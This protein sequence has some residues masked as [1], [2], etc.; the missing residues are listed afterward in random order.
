MKIRTLYILMAASM[1]FSSCKKSPEVFSNMMK[2]SPS[3]G[4][5]ESS[6]IAELL[7]DGM[8]MEDLEETNPEL[9]K[10]MQAY[11]QYQTTVLQK[12]ELGLDPVEWDNGTDPRIAQWSEVFAHSTDWSADAAEV[13]QKVFSG[14]IAGTSYY[15]FLQSL[16]K[17]NKYELVFFNDGS[18]ATVF[19]KTGISQRWLE[20]SLSFSLVAAI[21]CERSFE[22]RTEQDSRLT[23]LDDEQNKNE[24]EW[25]SHRDALVRSWNVVSD[26]LKTYQKQFNTVLTKVNIKPHQQW[27]D[28]HVAWIE[29]EITYSTSH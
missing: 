25:V 18:T 26:R 24:Q 7:D 27:I 20:L 3:E 9:L 14:E 22:L 10:T 2:N 16:G 15:R 28:Q 4:W 8:Y 29:K 1:A 13:F 23:F 19:D 21:A 6:I 5:V 12:S 17:K 11:L